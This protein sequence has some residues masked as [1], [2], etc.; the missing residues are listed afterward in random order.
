MNVE[1][2]ALP[3]VVILA[4]GLTHERDISLRSGSRLADSLKQK[5]YS[6]T[7]S[8]ADASLVTRLI[9]GP[10]DIVINSLHGGSGE[11]G[12]IQGILEMLSIPHVGTASRDCRLSWDK[13][14]AKCL[15]AAEGV[16]TPDWVTLSH[17]TFRDLGA[18]GLIATLIGYFGLPLIVKP[19][20]GGSGLGVQLA[21][22][23]EELS[24][25]LVHCFSYNDVALIELYV[26]GAEVAVFVVDGADGPK[27]LNPVEIVYQG[28]ILDYETR[29]T[30]GMAAFHCP[31]RLPEMAIENALHVALKAH[32][33]LRIKAISRTDFIIDDQGTAHF[34]ESTTSPGLTETSAL[35][36]AAAY[37]DQTIG[38]IYGEL[39]SRTLSRHGAEPQ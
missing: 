30:P 9:S 35:G 20:Q 16:D 32:E 19:S 8:D 39:I 31:A 34:L 26:K 27:A 22:T 17:S 24:T 21:N 28:N 18:S 13:P 1:L 6:V 33:I 5:G 25:A 15:V 38:D 12:A 29:Y 23:S 11:N 4:G 37:D 14:T 2:P 3:Y 7:V 10:P 36:I